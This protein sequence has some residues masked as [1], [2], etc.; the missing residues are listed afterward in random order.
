MAMQANYFDAMGP[1]EPCA[2][3]DKYFHCSTA[4]QPFVTRCRWLFGIC[5]IPNKSLGR[6]GFRTIHSSEGL[7]IERI[8]SVD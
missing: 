5:C 2:S 8:Y 7:H 1:Y 6:Q 4:S 3:C